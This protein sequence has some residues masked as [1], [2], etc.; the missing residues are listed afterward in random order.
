MT[1]P[2][3]SGTRALAT[4]VRYVKTEQP[5]KY[6]GPLPQLARSILEQPKGLSCRNLTTDTKKF[7]KHEDSQHDK[8]GKCNE[9]IN[10][11]AG[12]A[13]FLMG[14]VVGLG[15]AVSDTSHDSWKRSL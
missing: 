15:C 7:T 12:S 10:L 8:T 13:L 9:K 5:Y 11:A 3:L 1:I 4:L 14:F 2:S 6:C